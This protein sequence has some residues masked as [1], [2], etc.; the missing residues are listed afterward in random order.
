[1]TDELSAGMRRLPVY[2]LLDCSY[3]MQG[4]PINALRTGLS[5]LLS[6]LQADPQALETVWLSVITFH[7]TATQ[8]VP[9]T[10]IDQ[11]QEPDL[12][13]QGATSLGAGITMLMD[14]IESEIRKTTADQKGDYKPMI[15][16][17]TDGMP[18]DSW[19]GP[20][21]ELKRRRPG[22]VIACAAG[23]GADDSVLKQITEIVIRIETVTTGSMGAFLDWVTASIKTTSASVSAQ[24]DAPV[25]LPALPQDQG[26]VIVP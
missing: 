26:I 10:P 25:N 17:M 13:L 16:L 2:L 1:M 15:Y 5:A 3:S 18:T 22:N 21:N 8:L 23:P 6:D 4:E 20:A 14:C 19:Q 11:F 24:G 12:Q 7:S 9:L